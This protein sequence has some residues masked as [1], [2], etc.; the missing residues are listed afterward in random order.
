MENNWE[1]FVKVFDDKL[2]FDD[3]PV[4]GNN[5]KDNNKQGAY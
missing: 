5:K 2:L 3:G 1:W 4:Q